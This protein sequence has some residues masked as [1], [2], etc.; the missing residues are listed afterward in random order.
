M[1]VGHMTVRNATSFPVTFFALAGPCFKLGPGET[2]TQK[3]CLIWFSTRVQGPGAI[4]NTTTFSK[5][6]DDYIAQLDDL[7]FGSSDWDEG[8]SGAAAGSFLGLAVDGLEW[9]F[10]TP[11][12]VEHTQQGD[13][14]YFGGKKEGVYG[15]SNLVILADMDP[16]H[17]LDATHTP[18]W[19]LKIE[20]DQGQNQSKPTDPGYVYVT[21][22]L[23]KYKDY[24]FF[25]LYNVNYHNFMATSNSS[26]VCPLTTVDAVTQPFDPLTT[27]EYFAFQPDSSSP[28][29][30]RIIS[31]RNNGNQ[32]QTRYLQSANG[33]AVSPNQ[34]IDNNN[35]QQIYTVEFIDQ[36][37]V[38]KVK[39]SQGG[40]L[41]AGSKT[42]Q[43]PFMYP[44]IETAIDQQWYALTYTVDIHKIPTDHKF[45]LVHCKTGNLFN[46]FSNSIS[47][48]A[49]NVLSTANS[50]HFYV[51]A[52]AW[53]PECFVIY[54]LDE[55]NNEK[56]LSRTQDGHMITNSQNGEASVFSFKITDH[57]AG[58]HLVNGSYPGNFF[59]NGK[60]FGFYDDGNDY[61]DQLWICQF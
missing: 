2:Q 23:D 20:K 57:Q 44:R 10:K 38:T 50:V 31:T 8:G 1:A 48:S 39:I 58:F 9:V 18:W 41:L 16:A 60:N 6:R 51:K 5:Y 24:N 25:R 13:I 26:G 40:Y 12:T 11:N 47:M 15:T 29:N 19:H 52:T 49:D 36:A 22:N 27:G 56:Y 35:H 17:K 30:I 37:P 33:L 34:D 43:H 55:H 32:Q 14:L 21:P 28:Y 42:G 7:G 59:W 46:A 54:F 3:A 45:K 53:S 61:S 4:T